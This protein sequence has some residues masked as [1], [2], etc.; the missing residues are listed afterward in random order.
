MIPKIIHFCWLSGDEYP[1]LI[2]QCIH[3]WEKVLPEYKIIL[4]D[5]NRFQQEIN[6]EFAQEAYRLKKWAF[7]ADYVRLFALYKY[8]GI[9]LDSDVKVYKSFNG[10]L[11]NDFFSGIE[12]F[13]PTGYIAIEAAIMG[14]I[15][16]HPFIKDCLSLYHDARFVS[17]NKSLDQKPITQKIA[18][19]A[20]AKYNFKY[21]PNEQELPFR[22]HLYPP[23][24]FT[25]KS[26]AF[27]D[28]L[29]YAI[30][31][32]AGSWIDNKPSTKERFINFIKRYYNHPVTAI[33]N[34]FNKVN[35]K[36]RR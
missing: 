5:A 28:S 8:G 23:V 4:W 32:C 29:T 14:A 19:L 30:H 24:T 35:N 27:S 31:L 17:M 10:F 21:I 6:N 20:H 15:P 16:G 22:T 36:L 7:A 3:S 11:N 2:K 18:S 9:Y 12:Y 1:E 13:E 25:N 33:K 34:I 26:G